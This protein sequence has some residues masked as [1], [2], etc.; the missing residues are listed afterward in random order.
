MALNILHKIDELILRLK[1][2]DVAALD[3]LYDSYA[4]S[5]Y[6]I[7]IQIVRDGEIANTVLEKV[8]L[9]IWNNI[10]L[11]DPIN[12]RLFT[13]MFK[14]ARNAAINEIKA[15]NDGKILQ[16]E[17]DITSGKIESLEIDNYGLK[18]VIMELKNEHKILLDLCY[19]KG[20]TYEEIA[21]ALHIPVETVNKKL[22]VAILELRALL[23]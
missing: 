7:I 22:R 2:R 17:E 1:Q 21:A 6:T 19:Y 9:D 18:R 3:M 4:P 10:E 5:L 16:Q 23:V 15:E 20:Y 12:E 13:W 11:Y 14:I 8:F